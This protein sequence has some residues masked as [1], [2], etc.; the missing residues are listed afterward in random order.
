MTRSLIPLSIHLEDYLDALSM[1]PVELANALL[2]TSF[3][4]SATLSA[5]R[6]I[7]ADLQGVS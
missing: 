7:E 5:P 2:D 3:S 4:A 6:R 1:P